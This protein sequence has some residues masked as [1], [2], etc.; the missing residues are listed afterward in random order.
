[1]TASQVTAAPAGAISI[2]YGAVR[3]ATVSTWPE[4][5]AVLRR[6]ISDVYR[7]N[8][9]LSSPNQVALAHEAHELAQVALGP[10]SGLIVTSGPWAWGDS[11]RAAQQG[12]VGLT[13]GDLACAHDVSNGYSSWT[14]DVKVKIL[15]INAGTQR[16]TLRV[17]DYS[18][19]QFAPG[20]IVTVHAS[21]IRR[22][23]GRR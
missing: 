6:Q 14:I 7:P 21:K 3:V 20:E 8:G 5:Q 15:G 9:R 2:T 11:I 12:A 1:M 16:V 4:A 10:Q 19:S 23:S 18:A 13:A 22:R 17:T